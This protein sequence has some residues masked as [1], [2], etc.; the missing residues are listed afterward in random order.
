MS[1]TNLSVFFPQVTHGSGATVEESQN[2]AASL[3]LKTLADS[4]VDCSGASQAKKKL[5]QPSRTTTQTVTGDG[6]GGEEHDSTGRA[7]ISLNSKKKRSK[8][9]GAKAK[10]TGLA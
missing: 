4:G 8:T 1:E 5:L 3:A 9:T 10:A 2:N 6:S 7:L